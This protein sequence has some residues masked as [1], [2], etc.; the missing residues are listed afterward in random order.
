M[1]VSKMHRG[2]FK[3]IADLTQ[4]V[5]DPTQAPMQ[6]IQMYFVLGT[7]GLCW[8]CTLYVVYLI[9]FVLGNQYKGSVW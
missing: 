1:L 3:T 5:A 7:Q 2:Q 6:A 9:L 4:Y 8:A